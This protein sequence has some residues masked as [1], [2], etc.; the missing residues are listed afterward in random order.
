MIDKFYILNI[1]TETKRRDLCYQGICAA[2]TPAEKIEVFEASTPDTYEKTRQLCEAAAA[3]KFGFFQTLLDTKHYNMCHIGYLA[4]AWS[5]LRFYRHIQETGETA[6]LLHDDHL[7]RCSYDDLQN[8]CQELPASFLFAILQGNGVPNTKQWIKGTPWIKGF[9][10]KCSPQD[11][12]ILYNPNRVDFLFKY[13]EDNAESCAM[14]WLAYSLWHIKDKG[15]WTLLINPVAENL[16][17]IDEIF[18]SIQND[19]YNPKYMTIWSIP[20]LRYNSKLH[21]VETGEVIR[22]SELTKD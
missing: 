10:P 4:Q 13:L 2:G 3:E 11:F 9:V 17:H 6:V 8:A 7:F 15:I 21:K 22:P 12:G 20:E 18:E 16:V 1:A 14:G 5:Y 19:E